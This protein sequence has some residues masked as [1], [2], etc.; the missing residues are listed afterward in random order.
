M[1]YNEDEINGYGIDQNGNKVNHYW[2]N[3]R[4]TD[5]DLEE[6]K[7]WMDCLKD[8][9]KI[10]VKQSGISNK[11]IKGVEKRLGISLPSVIKLIYSYIGN[12]PSFLSS[13]LE[14]VSFL[15]LD[16]LYVDE[17]NL[18]YKTQGTKY[19]W[20]VDLEKD[21]MVYYVKGH[22][23]YWPQ[24]VMS[25]C[26]QSCTDLYCYALTHMKTVAYSRLKGFRSLYPSREG[27]ER[28]ADFFK[29]VPGFDYY[30]HTLFYNKEYGAIAWFRGGQFT[31]DILLG[32][33]DKEFIDNFVDTFQLTK[34][35]YKIIDN[36]IIKKKK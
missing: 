15:P 36:E 9:L 22:G 12:E 21:R 2:N 11:E 24:D 19:A 3:H 1:K 32:C 14:K 13:R 20:G 35:N 10:N 31:I 8:T 34:A 5:E 6:F 33:N 17:N 25:L 18:V 29:R 4:V 7:S 30:D 16:K 26:Q 27:E 28:Y 23:W